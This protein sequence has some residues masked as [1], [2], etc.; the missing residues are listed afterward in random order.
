MTE[1]FKI[2]GVAFITTFAAVLLKQTKPELSFAVTV[3]GV[4]IILLFIVEALQNTLAVFS[5]IVAMTGIENGLLKI[6]IKIV[7]VGYLTEFG[8]GI[9]QDFGSNSLAD[10]VLVGGKITIV[11]LSLPVIE[12]LLSMMKGF[13]QLV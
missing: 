8:A 4:I 7:G 12:G 2:I 11:L 9:L 10:K 3:T 5:S 1:L 13:L 6:L